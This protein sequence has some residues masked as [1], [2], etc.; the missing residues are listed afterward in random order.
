[1]TILS[2]HLGF[3]PSMSR[4]VAIYCTW[5]PTSRVSDM[6]LKQIATYRDAGFDVIVVSNSPHL[7]VD[8]RNEA[9]WVI[10]R[11]N[12]D[13]DF[14]AWKAGLPFMQS[15]YGT[16]DEVLLVNDSVLGPT[17][18]LTSLVETMRGRGEGVFG[19]TDCHLYA[20]HLQSYF[21]LVRGHRAIASVHDFFDALPPLTDKGEAIQR[22]EI[23]FS[24]HMINAGHHVGAEYGYAAVLQRMYRTEEGLD[25]L[26]ALRPPG[27]RTRHN[28][29]AWERRAVVRR[30]EIAPFNPTHHLWLPL[31]RQGFP[32]VKTELVRRNPGQVPGVGHLE[33][34]WPSSAL[35]S[36][37][38]VRAHLACYETQQ[39]GDTLPAAD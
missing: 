7:D 10:H 34:W 36:M 35:V 5:S 24:Q 31:L 22:G 38:E 12:V 30:A 26:N 27:R 21:L 23:G 32:F 11:Q 20:E 33:Q 18:P 15:V 25:W 17:R 4:S 3:Y 13:H 1:M 16:P 37:A 9:S 8:L 2:T 29:L 19:L 39:K 6:V 14:G 28:A